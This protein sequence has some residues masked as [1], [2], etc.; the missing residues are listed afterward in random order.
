MASPEE[1]WNPK[2]SVPG[3]EILLC[4]MQI[5]FSHSLTYVDLSSYSYL[6]SDIK[7]RTASPLAPYFALYS[8]SYSILT[9]ALGPIRFIYWCII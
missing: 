7:S 5:I 4:K 3:F 9:S 8:S 6:L 2:H 1:D